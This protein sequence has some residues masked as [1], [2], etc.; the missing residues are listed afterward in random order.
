MMVTIGIFSILLAVVSLYLTSAQC[1]NACTVSTGQLEGNAAHWISPLFRTFVSIDTMMAAVELI[2]QTVAFDACIALCP[3]VCQVPASAV[4]GVFLVH[5]SENSARKTK[6]QR[7]SAAVRR[8]RWRASP[9]ALVIF[10]L[11]LLCGIN[12]GWVVF[13]PNANQSAQA[14]EVLLASFEHEVS[15]ASFE[16]ETNGPII[17]PSWDEIDPTSIVHQGLCPEG[18]NEGTV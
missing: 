12:H 13:T 5:E 4:V 17:Q 9:S 8:H 14:K 6:V 11:A 10:A 16:H 7:H 2:L 3:S 15:L 1:C 18:Q